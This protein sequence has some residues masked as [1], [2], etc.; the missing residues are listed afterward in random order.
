M[1][2]SFK[3]LAYH[4]EKSHQHFT[5]TY[6]IGSLGSNFSAV[7]I[8]K[9]KRNPVCAIWAEWGSAECI[10]KC[11]FPEIVTLTSNGSRVL[12]DLSLNT[13]RNIPHSNK[14][15]N[16]T[17]ISQ[18]R[19]D[20][21][22]SDWHASKNAHSIWEKSRQS[23]TAKTEGCWIREF[24]H[25]GGRR[26]LRTRWRWNMMT[27]RGMCTNRRVVVTSLWCHWCWALTVK[28]CLTKWFS[29]S[30]GLFQLRHVNNLFH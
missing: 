5:L 10:S 25:L 19:R 21:L 24:P 16:N 29:L 2:H 18:C 27:F 1:S 4:H 8:E 12:G 28:A 20:I 13:G 15:L 30:L 23:E 11:H 14:Y 17:S 22:T 9:R 3:I 7:K 6:F 26:A